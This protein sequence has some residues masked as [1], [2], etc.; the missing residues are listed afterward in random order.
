MLNRFLKA[1][2][3]AVAVPILTVTFL[4]ATALEKFLNI[5]LGPAAVAALMTYPVKLA[6]NA[7][8]DANV[9]CVKSFSLLFLG[10]LLTQAITMVAR[11]GNGR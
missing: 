11:S 8:F 5:I 3:Y 1:T 6:F 2:V 10:L 7:G 4:A 9:G